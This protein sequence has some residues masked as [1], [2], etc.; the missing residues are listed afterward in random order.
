MGGSL[1]LGLQ[2][3]KLSNEEPIRLTRWAP[4]DELYP[5]LQF[6]WT[7]LIYALLVAVMLS[8]QTT[9][10]KVNEVTPALF[11]RADNPEKMASLKLKKFKFN[12]KSDSRQ[13]SQESQIIVNKYCKRR[14][15]YPGLGIL[16][17]TC[18]CWTQDC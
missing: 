5:G 3:E 16:R 4:L 2:D 17:I 7:I 14:R 15:N 12:Q 18:R 11:A 13:Q 10:K 6:L 8:A 9:D 1:F